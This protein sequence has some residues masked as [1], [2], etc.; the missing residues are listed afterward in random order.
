MESKMIP[1]CLCSHP[2]MAH[3]NTGPLGGCAV[4]GCDCEQFNEYVHDDHD[5]PET[6]DFS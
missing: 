2:Y 6:Y 1:V 5:P 4:P 3:T